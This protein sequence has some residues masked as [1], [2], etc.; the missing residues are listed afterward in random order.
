MKRIILPCDST[1]MFIRCNSNMKNMIRI[2]D[3]LAGISSPKKDDEIKL[4]CVKNKVETTLEI[5][6]ISPYFRS[7]SPIE[8][9][10]FLNSKDKF[11]FFTIELRTEELINLQYFLVMDRFLRNN[12]ISYYLI[13][14]T[15]C[16][17]EAY[18]K[19]Y[20]YFN[21]RYLPIYN[22]V[23]VRNEKNI[24]SLP[25]KDMNYKPG[26][27]VPFF[28]VDYE[29]YES[30]FSCFSF[31]NDLY[32]IINESKDKNI[33]KYISEYCGD[34]SKT[35]QYLMRYIYSFMIRNPQKAKPIITFLKNQP[36]PPILCVLLFVAFLNKT[37][38]NNIDILFENCLD[39]ALSLEQLIENSIFYA[40]SGVL[41]IRIHQSDSLAMSNYCKD[42]NFCQYFLEI[43][44]IDYQEK[45]ENRSIIS[46]FVKYAD[47]EGSEKTELRNNL[48]SPD[49][50]KELF[51]PNSKDIVRKY[52]KKPSV[53]IQHYGLQTISILSQKTNALLCVRSGSGFYTNRQNDNLFYDQ[54]PDEHKY[55]SGLYYKIVIPIY[56]S[57][58]ETVY[59]GF[60]SNKYGD[61][62]ACEEYSYFK[63]EEKQTNIPKTRTEKLNSIKDLKES[64][65]QKYNNNNIFVIDAFNIGN[66]L[67]LE[68]V[69]KAAL[70]LVYEKGTEN[71]PVYIAIIGLKNKTFVKLALRFISLCYNRKGVNEIFANNE[72]FLCSKD[73]GIEILISGEN[74]NEIISNISAQRVFGTVDD[75]IFDEMQSAV[76]IMD[77][78]EENEHSKI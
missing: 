59:I 24:I 46:Q 64:M 66:R 77:R 17:Q 7:S 38:F 16:T 54:T 50:L 1:V 47:V 14:N 37:F 8:T 49:S 74:Y 65:I 73:C 19:L 67:Y 5:N 27:I 36:E 68:Y 13:I 57:S 12:N 53:L 45:L 32:K 35:E 15:D 43:S 3:I 22:N 2:P 55:T 31:D 60:D 71:K 63:L 78:S 52:Y 58:K 56:D 4:K 21:M 29:F 30:C 26:E 10:D 51:Q 75:D 33:Q 28:F 48:L 23:F 9:S 61:F 20:H 70:S 76:L 69:V 34:K 44:L 41:S 72:I 42:K 62:N 40:T 18:F 11:I 6:D 25:A 39:Y